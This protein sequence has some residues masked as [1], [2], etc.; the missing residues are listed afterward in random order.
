MQENRASAKR[1]IFRFE[2]STVHTCQCNA[3]AGVVSSRDVRSCAG[4]NCGCSYLER[5]Q[6]GGAQDRLQQ[7]CKSS[8]G[9][10]AQNCPIC[11]QLLQ[12]GHVKHKQLV[13][14]TAI[15]PGLI[16]HLQVSTL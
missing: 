12:T 16:A 6:A 7:P 15:M 11:I 1:C 4:R 5:V 3:Q 8:A 9:L 10:S 14:P 13:G 2:G